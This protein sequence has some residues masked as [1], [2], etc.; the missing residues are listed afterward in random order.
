MLFAG[1]TGRRSKWVGSQMSP[2]TADVKNWMHLFRWIVKLI[3][4]EFG[5]DETRLVRDAALETDLGLSLEQVEQVLDFTA[6]AFELTFPDGTLNEVL[7]LEELCM[8]AAW[9]AGLY[10]RPPFLGDDFA[11][12][13]RAI[14]SRAAAA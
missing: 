10:K 13:C 7:R 1:L 5:I 4:D 11:A 9:L 8:L 6:D 12:S 3:R 14:N 2:S